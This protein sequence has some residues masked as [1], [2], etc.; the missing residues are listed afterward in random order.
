MGSMATLD[1]TNRVNFATYSDESLLGW[2][3]SQNELLAPERVI[4]EQLRP[5]LANKRLLDIGV[6]GG[7]TTKHLLEISRD[8]T[9][10]D[11]SPQFVSL[12]SRKFWIDSV[13]NCDARDLSRFRDAA[14]DFVLFSFNGLDYV[15]HEG[16]LTALRE[17]HR[18]LEPGGAFVFSTHNRSWRDLGKMP[19]HRSPKWRSGFVKDCLTALVHTGRRRRM[20]RLEQR[21]TEYAILND[22]A[23]AY[24]LLHYHIAIPDQI[25]Q[26]EAI[27]FGDTTAYN[28]RGE[29]VADDTED[30]T[31][32]F[33]TRKRANG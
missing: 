5:E 6:G 1:D 19:W 22:I 11:Y 15:D 12:V 29:A 16:R 8:Y 17:V 24:S 23:H 4:L 3:D 32:H 28:M 21:T 33:L 25:R 7:R 9:G 27:G 20:R 18:V 26:L 2:Y 13:F 14:F 30:G 31:T 10:I